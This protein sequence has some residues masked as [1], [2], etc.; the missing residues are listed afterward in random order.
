MRLQGDHVPITLQIPLQHKRELE[1]RYLEHPKAGCW[2]GPKSYADLV[3]QAIAEFLMPQPSPHVA[4]Q[5][6]GKPVQRMQPA[7]EFFVHMRAVSSDDR[8]HGPS[9][10]GLRDLDE[11]YLTTQPANADCPKCRGIL[12]ANAKALAAPAKTKAAK[13]TR[14]PRPPGSKKR[15]RR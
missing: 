5:I 10:C 2:G 9:I 7:H 13:R 3:R 11:E 14:A 6:A 8:V 12:D 1:R 4:K 15:G